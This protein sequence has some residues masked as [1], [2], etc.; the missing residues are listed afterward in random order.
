M[1]AMMQMDDTRSLGKVLFDQLE[2]RH[3]AE[4]SAAVWDAQ[5][6]YGGDYNKLW[7]RSEGERVGGKT[8]DARADVLWDRNIARWW[9]LQAGARQ[10]FGEGPSRT[11]AA[12]GVQGLAPYW[13]DV[14]ATFYVG[15]E[16]RTAA[17]LRTECDL[18][19]TQRLIL[20]P[21]AELN[22]YG[23]A[24]PARQIGSG[25]SDLD[26]GLRL[27]YEF[28]REFAPYVGVSWRKLFGE[29]A[30]QARSAG[31]GASDVQFLAGLRIW[32]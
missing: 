14:E 6:W 31:A 11:W 10:D 7:I 13:F 23:K 4:G 17:R 18:L 3:T 12:L 8:H 1:A 15:E 21:E 19:L 28:R 16:G 22:A 25:V 26:L 2:W 27:R 20:Q 9:S 24:D 5:G 30:D 29:T 32:F